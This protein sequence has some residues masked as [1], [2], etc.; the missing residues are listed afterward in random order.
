M[1]NIL[2]LPR[3][4]LCYLIKL[5]QHTFSPDH[6]AFCKDRHPFGYCKYRPTCSEYSY[7]VVKKHGVIWGGLKALWRIVR[8]NP[9]SKGGVDFPK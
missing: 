3:R 8:C 1:R 5:Y 4:G 7:E 6:G 9:W 2:L